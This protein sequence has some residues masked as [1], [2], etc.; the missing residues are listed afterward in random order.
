M[1]EKRSFKEVVDELILP[2]IGKTKGEQKEALIN[3]LKDKCFLLAFVEKRLAKI[4]AQACEKESDPEKRKFILHDYE[5]DRLDFERQRDKIASLFYL[6]T[7]LDKVDF[8]KKTIHEVEFSSEERQEF[9]AK[10]RQF[11]KT[12]SCMASYIKE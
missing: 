10:T 4:F 11:I 5:A 3:L 8:L 6:L 1:S 12:Y 2:W 7:G 9:R